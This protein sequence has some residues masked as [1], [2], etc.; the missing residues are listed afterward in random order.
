MK[1]ALSRALRAS[2]AVA[3]VAGLGLAT[4]WGWESVA[5]QPVTQVRFR[6][7][8]GRVN[9]ADLERLAA[10]LRGRPANSVPLGELRDAVRAMAWVR[11]ATVRRHYP[12]TLEVTLDVHEPLARWDAERLVSVDGE[13]FAAEFDEPMPRFVGPE[14]AA[15]TM[16]AQWAR[17]QDAAAPLGSPVAELRLNARGAWQIRLASGLSIDLGRSDIEARLARFAHAWPRVADSAA[18]ATHVD[19]R[20]PNGFAVRGAVPEKSPPARPRRA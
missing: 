8:V 3:V 11:E 15:P 14:G 9:A 4:W 13:V 19:L 1:P 10:G 17:L 18:K 6:G 7:E 20:Y 12:G 5:A 2:A 16:V